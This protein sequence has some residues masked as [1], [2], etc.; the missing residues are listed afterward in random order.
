M[1]NFDNNMEKNGRNRGSDRL[2][3]LEPGQLNSAGSNA[4]K[5]LIVSPRANATGGLGKSLTLGGPTGSTRS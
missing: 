4:N 1:Q 2:R 3:S 5:N